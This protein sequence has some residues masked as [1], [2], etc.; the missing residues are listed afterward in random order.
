MSQSRL[1][2]HDVFLV[3]YLDNEERQPQKNLTCVCLL[4]PTSRNIELIADEVTNPKYLSYS[5]SKEVKI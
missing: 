1:F 2:E 3:D 5:L 4:R